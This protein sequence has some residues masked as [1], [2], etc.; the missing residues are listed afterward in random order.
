MFMPTNASPDAV[1][2]SMAVLRNILQTRFDHA[3]SML[4]LEDEIDRQ[5]LDLMTRK[6]NGEELT[7]QD[8]GLLALY[9]SL[10]MTKDFFEA[11]VGMTAQVEAEIGE[12]PTL[13]TFRGVAGDLQRDLDQVGSGGRFHET[14]AANA[15]THP[16]DDKIAEAA[17]AGGS[18]GSFEFELDMQDEQRQRDADDL[19]VVSLVKRLVADTETGSATWPEIGML[20][21]QNH[22]FWKAYASG[23]Q[24]VE[25]R[26]LELA[27]YALELFEDGDLAEMLAEAADTVGDIGEAWTFNEIVAEEPDNTYVVFD[28]AMVPLGDLTGL[29]AAFRRAADFLDAVYIFKGMGAAPNDAQRPAEKP[30]EPQP[31]QNVVSDAETI[32]RKVIDGVVFLGEVGKN[33]KTVLPVVQQAYKTPE[34]RALITSMMGPAFKRIAEKVRASAG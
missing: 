24:G 20:L 26:H 6:P 14:M 2:E 7:L 4:E 5:A 31:E 8:R 15:G 28:G 27:I 23:V 11:M 17:R 1:I 3:P 12:G 22:Q 30:S 29:D 10:Q 21:Q 34:G 33:F 13:D 16:G 18:D 19:K 9:H 32:A 25:T